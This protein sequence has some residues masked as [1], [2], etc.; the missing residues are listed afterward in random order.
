LAAQGLGWQDIGRSSYYGDSMNDL[1]LLEH[2]TEPVAT[3]PSDAL[4][5]TAVQRGWRVM[6]LFAS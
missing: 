5:A 4:R 3:N 6:D 2:V 1:P